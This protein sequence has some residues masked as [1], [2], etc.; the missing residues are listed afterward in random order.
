MIPD[1]QVRLS[2]MAPGGGCAAKIGPGTLQGILEQL[3]RFSDENLLVGIETNDDGAVYRISDEL[4][5]IQTLDF[6]P[7]VVD[8]PW[9]FGQIAA[10]NA[11]SDI[12]AMGGEP[13][14]ALNIV[15]WPNCVNPDILGK[16]LAGGAAKVKEAGAVLA[17]GHS[18]Q[19]DV[20]K[21]GLSVTGFVDPR[22][23]FTNCG[24]RPGDMLL[25]TKPLG[26]GLVNTAVKAEMASE[27]AEKEVLRVMTELNRQAAELLKSCANGGGDSGAG[28]GRDS[29]AGSGR[30]SGG[31][32]AC[33][34]VTGFGLAGHGAEMG[35]GS[36]VT[37]EI[38]LKKLPILP[39]AAEYASMG[40]V[41]EGSYR[42]RE[43]LKDQVLVKAGLPWAADLVF[44]PQTSGGL[45]VSADPETAEILERESVKLGMKDPFRIIG[46]VREEEPWSV[47]LTD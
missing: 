12:Y 30:T 23:M 1:D 40:L 24:A 18:I 5:L 14:I 44:D 25:L 38:S 9:M 2:Q 42:N 41:P 10:A 11:L 22:R 21:Y 31:I 34:D 3:P 46:T 32:H 29:G 39:E 28:S 33:T 8:N 6:F 19:D 15:A 7:P 20:P 27:R 13:K 37:L 4:A 45:L 43:F 47:I 16:I 17:G 26:I 36:G 35:K